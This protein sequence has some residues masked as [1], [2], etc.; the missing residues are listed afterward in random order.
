MGYDPRIG[1]EFLHPGPGYGGSC[2]P[3]DTAALHLHRRDRGLRLQPA[4]R[5]RRGQPRQHER[6]VEKVRD[7]VG[8]S[9]RGRARS[10]CGASRS[11]PTPTTS[12]TRPRWWCASG[13]SRRAPR[14]RAYDPA[15]GEAAAAQ[16]PG[17][18]RGRRPVRRGA[19]RAAA[20]G[21][22]RVGR[23][24][25][26]RLRPGRRRHDRAARDSSTPATCSTPR[27]CAGAGS[28][29]RASAADAA[30]G[31][32]RRGGVRRVAPLRRAARARVGGRR[33]RQL[34]HRPP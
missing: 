32:H 27:R 15:A 25:L 31:R 1:F 33:G 16:L 17:A 19:R 12:A 14:V 2:F 21:A 10:A 6:M 3:K 7:A 4:A 20:R 8:G 13:C 30:C 22:H 9:L 34:P 28:P 5:G 18:R 11:R 26:A 23:V 29:T 24:P